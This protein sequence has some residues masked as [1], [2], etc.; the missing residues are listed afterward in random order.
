MKY[1]PF[2]N[3]MKQAATPRADLGIADA[4]AF[5]LS[6]ARRVPEARYVSRQSRAQHA[7]ARRALQSGEPH[8]RS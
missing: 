1:K 6:P 3:P 2:A 8:G 5:D 7:T 4:S